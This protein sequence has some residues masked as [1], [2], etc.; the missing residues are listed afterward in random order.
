MRISENKVVLM[1]ESPKR[2]P[3]QR[4]SQASPV[5]ILL[6]VAALVMN[7]LGYMKYPDSGKLRVDETEE[8]YDPDEKP[9]QVAETTQA[10]VGDILRR[11]DL[12]PH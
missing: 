4:T 8:F 6:V 12:G 10:S 2:E 5:F 9:L 11:D 1:S 7:Q 3:L